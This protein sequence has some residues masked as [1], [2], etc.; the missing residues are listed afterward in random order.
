[1]FS[2][3]CLSREKII[4]FTASSLTNVF[5][6]IILEYAKQ[7]NVKILLSSASSSTLARQVESG[8][9]ADIFVSAN[10]KWVNY[11]I[12]KKIAKVS[13]T[14]SLV[15]NELVLI[16][17]NNSLQSHFKMNADVNFG[18]LL[19]TSRLAM[20]NP[21]VVPAGIYAKEA[22]LY[23][24]KWNSVNK[25]ITNSKNVRSALML[26]ERGESNIGITYKTD[27]ILSK[28]VK[29]ISRFPQESH[30]QIKYLAS[31][32]NMNESIKSFVSFLKSEKSINI[33]KKYGFGT[34]TLESKSNVN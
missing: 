16:A 4:I 17:P 29:V 24:K 31:G 1:M 28:K 21:D 3:S 2:T 20:A 25:L 19:N 12:E 18:S 27:A 5:Q 14:F 11:L 15:S 23:F 9:P 26:V 7:S 34:E 8:A 32:L 6:D 33:F 13:N 30:S 22:L 10:T